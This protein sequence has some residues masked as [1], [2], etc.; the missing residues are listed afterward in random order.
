MAERSY[1]E[2]RSMAEAPRD[3]SRV[4]VMLRASE[5]GPA[6]V[7]VA[8]WGKLKPGGECWM[9][10]DSEHDCPVAYADGE[11]AGWMPLPSPAPGLRATDVSVLEEWRKRVAG[12]ET[13][14]S[15]I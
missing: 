7:D 14:G 4:L 2:W 5:Q 13:G 1:G 15:G 10:A 12:R 6:E 11:L 9:A 8:R 3:G